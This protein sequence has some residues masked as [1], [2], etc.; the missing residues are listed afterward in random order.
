M[1][2]RPC[3]S[4]IAISFD[5]A[6]DFSPNFTESHSLPEQIDSIALGFPAPLQNWQTD[7]LFNYDIFP[8][9]IMRFEAEWIAENRPMRVGDIILQRAI[10]PPIGFGIC[11]EFAV[12]I[13]SLIGEDSRL[14]FAYETL[15]GHAEKGVSEFYFE[16]KDSE[17]YFTIRTLSEPGHWLSRVARNFTLPYQSWC[18]N[19]ALKHVRSRFRH[20]NPH[21]R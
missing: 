5:R 6:K 7:F 18:T 1:K 11:I 9:S 20:K 2:I 14:G 12:R 15:T 3:I 21:K 10:L 13:C 16:S 8:K 4:G 17:L 19:R